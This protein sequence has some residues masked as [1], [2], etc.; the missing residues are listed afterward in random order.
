MSRALDNL[1]PHLLGRVPSE[2]DARNYDLGW[3]LSDDPLD[4]ALANVLRSHFVAKSQKHFDSAVVAAIKGGPTPAPPAPGP[5]PAPTPTDA[6]WLEPDQPVL[7]QGQTGHCVGDTGADW[8]NALPV[9]NHLAQSDADDIYYACKVIDGEPK[10]ED[11]SSIHSLAKVLVERN[12]LKTYAFATNIDDAW[13]FVQTSGPIC[14]GI[15][16]TDSMFTPDDTGLVVPIGP[17]VGGHAIIQYGT[18]GPFALLLNHWGTS[19]GVD[20][21]FRMH[22]SDLADRLANGGEAMAG[23]ELAA[24]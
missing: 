23:V 17:D 4:V 16:W 9:G 19:W 2:P 10:A 5:T 14:W 3:F 8:E 6:N 20:G 13:K 24:A 1:G 7:D 18:D 15:G 22:K 21:K 11:G 12:R